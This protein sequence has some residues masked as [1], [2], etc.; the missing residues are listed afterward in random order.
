MSGDI[1]SYIEKFLSHRL[2]GFRRG[3]ST[4]LSLIVMLEY[5]RQNIDN[6]KFSGMLV[7]DLS[8]AFDCLVHDLLIVKLDA[9]GFDYNALRLIY[10]YLSDRKQ[11]TRI[12]ESYSNWTD[13]ILGVP[14]GSILGPLLFNIYINDIFYFTEVTTITNFADDNTLYICDK[15]IDLVISKLEKDSNNLGQWFKANYF[16]SNELLLNRNAEQFILVGNVSI[17]NSTEAQLLG[18]TFNSALKFDAHVSK[19]CKK[20][21]QKLHA[22]LR[23]SMYMNYE[24]RKIIMKSFTTSQ[25]GYYPL[26]W[27]FH[28]R[29][30]NDQINKIHERVLRSVYNDFSSTFE[31]LLIKDNSVSIHHRNLQV[32]A[33][34]IFNAMN[35]LRPPILKNVF[36]V[37]G[38]PY[39]LRRGT[40][41]ITRNV[42]TTSYGIETLS[43]RGP[44]LW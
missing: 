12:D 42:K 16:K 30:S 1:N 26:G 44:K 25:F 3:Y 37:K 9:Y 39:N 14:Q 10:N 27:M 21:N 33:T 8:K 31:E 43:F 29:G 11:R 40:T 15:S 35:D 28:S 7:T 2:C 13:I 34:E 20:A 41:L 24:K 6:G 32:L 17:Y 22:L 23:V 18:V 4:Q 19:L 38:S 5:I 36:Q